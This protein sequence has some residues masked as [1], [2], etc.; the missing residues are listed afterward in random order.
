MLLLLLPLLLLLLFVAVVAVVAIV[1]VLAVLA[2][3][4]CLK[5]SFSSLRQTIPTTCT[6]GDD[7]IVIKKLAVYNTIGLQTFSG[8]QILKPTYKAY[9]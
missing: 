4:C 2:V 1:A 9:L 5:N 7:G 3:C 6:A 8:T